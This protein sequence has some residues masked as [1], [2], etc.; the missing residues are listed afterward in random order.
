MEISQKNKV[1]LFSEFAEFCKI[2]HRELVNYQPAMVIGETS[3]HKREEELMRFKTDPNCRVLISSS[4]GAFG[5][6]LTEANYILH[7]D[8]PWSLA[9]KQQRE[10]RAHRMGQKKS[11]QIFNLLA[12]KTVDYYIK[13]VLHDK[14]GI[15]AKVLGDDK[16]TMNAIK[17]ILQYEGA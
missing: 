2:L 9:K 12:E 5:L 1:I 11:V 13:K 7:A 15:S 17:E 8:Q 14:A 16:I 4:A 10:G 6:N 3:L